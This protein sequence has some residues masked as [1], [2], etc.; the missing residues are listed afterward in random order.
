MYMH[1]YVGIS[2]YHL[3]LTFSHCDKIAENNHRMRGEIILAYSCRDGS[4][5]PYCFG[6]LLTQRIMMGPCC[7]LSLVTSRGGGAHAHER[8]GEGEGEG[9]IF[10]KGMPQLSNFLLLS[11]SCNGFT[12]SLGS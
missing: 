8:E 1:T 7:G 12:T 3:L 10:F 5:W 11:L 6:A 4:P 2:I 9:E